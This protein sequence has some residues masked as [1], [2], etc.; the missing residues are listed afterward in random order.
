MGQYRKGS[1][2]LCQLVAVVLM[3]R[4]TVGCAAVPDEL[5]GLAGRVLKASEDI[6][7]GAVSKSS[8]SVSFVQPV[9]DEV[10]R[11]PGRFLTVYLMLVDLS[12]TK[13]MVQKCW[14]DV[15]CELSTSHVIRSIGGFVLILFWCNLLLSLQNYGLLVTRKCFF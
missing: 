1:F 13:Q 10:V 2:N 11:K 4:V 15:A 9:E 12:V 8:D 3:C 14:I 6:P 7:G 5:E